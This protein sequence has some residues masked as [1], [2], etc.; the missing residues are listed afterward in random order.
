VRGVVEK[1]GKILVHTQFDCWLELYILQKITYC[2]Y[3]TV[4]H[5]SLQIRRDSGLVWRKGVSARVGSNG[6]MSL[7][8]IKVVAA[9]LFS[10][11]LT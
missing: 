10:Q 11:Y 8:V 9:Y 6:D 1:R 7:P 4:V 5:C 3:Q 2:I